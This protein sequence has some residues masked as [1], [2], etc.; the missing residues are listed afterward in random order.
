MLLGL[1]LIELFKDK[2]RG[3]WCA[4]KM[5]RAV[6]ITK[7]GLI[8]KSTIGKGRGVTDPLTGPYFL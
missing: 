2:I 1:K 5:L 7:K 3:L 4:L 6:K 8:L